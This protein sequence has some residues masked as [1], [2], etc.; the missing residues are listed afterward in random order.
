MLERL[1]QYNLLDR[2]GAGAIGEVYR[3]RDTR[4]GRTVVVM[5]LPPAIAADDAQRARLA[6]DVR[7]ASTLSHP[8][9]AILYELGEDQGRVFL[10]FEF[11]PGDLLS[12]VIAGRPM[13][14]RRALRLASQIA[15][16]LAEIHASGLVHG[17]VAPDTIMVTPK[18]T[19]KLLDAGL[20]S[21][22]VRRTDAYRAP[23]GDEAGERGDVFAL[24]VITHEMLTGV[25]PSR[26]SASTDTLQASRLPA[27]VSDLLTR[28]LAVDPDAR[29]SSAATFAAGLRAVEEALD[30]RA[31]VA[32]T[33]PPEPRSRPMWPIAVLL[34][35]AVAL[36]AW[37]SRHLLGW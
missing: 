18:D 12:A 6:A 34:M 24:A 32:V 9:I 2:I 25:P 16:A 21:W 1:G 15:D 23:E 27:G 26:G 22:T 5:V 30:Q 28:A 13:N 35:I 4:G 33:L 11:V 36:A 19:A 37:F 20:S 31:V 7:A 3:A 10:V 8:N 29:L 14:P 17:D